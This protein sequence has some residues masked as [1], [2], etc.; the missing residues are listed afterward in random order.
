M[1]RLATARPP[2][3]LLARVWFVVRVVTMATVGILLTVP[4]ILGAGFIGTLTLSGGGCGDGAPPSV[5]YEDVRLLATESGT[6][7]IPAYFV[8]AGANAD[9]STII[10]LPTGAARGDR[11]F[12]WLAYHDAGYHVLTFTARGCLT[13]VN[14]LGALEALQ[15]GDALTYLRGRADVDMTRIGAHGFSQ[16]GAAAILAAARYLD[17]RAVVAEGGYADFPD[18]IAQNANATRLGILS[19]LFGFGSGIAYRARVGIDISALSPLSVIQSIAPRPIL[20]IYGTNEPGLRGAMQQLQAA[21]RGGGTS[22]T[23]WTIAG[24]GHGGYVGAVSS[25]EYARRVVAFMDAALR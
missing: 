16:A 23:L 21:N 8:P 1:R 11:A 22:A 18:E 3:T 24:A 10:A 17:V 15:V 13:T 4:T 14:S 19:G 20:L 12:E 5:P 7:Y 2:K 9:G 25:G 6:D